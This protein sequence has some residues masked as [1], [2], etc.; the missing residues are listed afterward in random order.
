MSLHLKIGVLM[1]DN[2]NDII[3][4]VLNEIEAS[5]QDPKGMALHQRRLAF[6]LSL[7]AVAIIEHYL[8]TQNVLKKGSGLASA[9]KKISNS[10]K[11]VPLMQSS[12]TQT[13]A[14]LFIVNPF[15][16]GGLVTLFQTHPSVDVRVKKLSEM[17]F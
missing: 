11:Q 6:V 9:L 8:S 14:H 3:N 13:T 7:G 1:A 5:L 12:Q 16:G 10:V 17:K 4:E 15:R 2:Y